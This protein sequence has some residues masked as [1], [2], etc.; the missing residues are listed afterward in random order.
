MMPTTNMV[1]MKKFK[2]LWQFKSSRTL[3]QFLKRGTRV[4]VL[5]MSHQRK[6]LVVLSEEVTSVLL[7][8]LR[9]MSM[10]ISNYGMIITIT[11]MTRSRKSP[12][13]MKTSRTLNNSHL[14]QQSRSKTWDLAQLQTSGLK[15]TSLLQVQK[16][17]KITVYKQSS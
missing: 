3:M 10:S 7:S 13:I 6:A 5:Q 8:H 12:T 1:L 14:T 16:H 9:M 4:I 15:T 11:K 17:M 2:K